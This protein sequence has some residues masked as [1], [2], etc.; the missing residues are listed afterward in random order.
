MYP[1]QFA[2]MNVASSYWLV[3]AT[4]CRSDDEPEG[5]GDDYKTGRGC[6]E[7]FSVGLE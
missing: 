7:D 6:A 5:A 2:H 3:L 1:H 4:L